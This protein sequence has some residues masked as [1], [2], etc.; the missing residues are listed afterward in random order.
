[1]GC[2]DWVTGVVIG[3]FSVR[4]GTAPAF[5]PSGRLLTRRLGMVRAATLVAKAIPSV[6][7]RLSSSARLSSR[8]LV[9]LRV[10]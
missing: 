7:E 1:M 2:V 9:P 8:D 6:S 4:A 10:I 5:P 3:W